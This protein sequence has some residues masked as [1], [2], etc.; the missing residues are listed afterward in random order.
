[1]SSIT[2]HY[3]NAH[4]LRGLAERLPQ[5][6]SQEDAPP[7][8]IELLHRLAD[9]EIEQA[10]YDEWVREKVARAL[11]DPH[12]GWTIEEAKEQLGLHP[13]EGRKSA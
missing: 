1:M 11:A 13:I 5:L 4:F 3:E 8:Q 6:L 2:P 7:A 10:E 9:D 12:P